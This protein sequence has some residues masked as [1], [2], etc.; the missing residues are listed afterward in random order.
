MSLL[1]LRFM[2]KEKEL[3]AYSV[4]HHGVKRCLFCNVLS[5]VSVCGA[6]VH[7]DCY[8]PLDMPF[9]MDMPVDSWSLRFVFPAMVGHFDSTETP[10]CKLREELHNLSRAP[11]NLLFAA[12]RLKRTGH[13][14]VATQHRSWQTIKLAALTDAGQHELLAAIMASVSLSD[15]HCRDRSAGNYMLLLYGDD[16]YERSMTWHDVID[17]HVRLLPEPDNFTVLGYWPSTF[18]SVE[19]S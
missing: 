14:S 8:R 2:K 19:H 5:N 10:D 12:Y 4:E 13:G 15:C 1:L 11:L 7:Q 9:S 6:C 18:D 16:E 3:E 17:L